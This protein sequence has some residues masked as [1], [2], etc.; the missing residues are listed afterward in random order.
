MLDY[1]TLEHVEGDKFMMKTSG[2]GGHG[3]YAVFEFE[4]GKIKRLKTGEN[5][6][7]PIKEW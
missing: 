2:Y 5:Y 1:T 7:Y 6:T 3:E 4:D